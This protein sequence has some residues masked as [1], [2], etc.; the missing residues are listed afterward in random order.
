M[1]GREN[2]REAGT[3]GEFGV[4]IGVSEDHSHIWSNPMSCRKVL[5][6]NLVQSC[7]LILSIDI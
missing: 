6:V 7:N 5:W 2:A 4:I 3:C 1:L